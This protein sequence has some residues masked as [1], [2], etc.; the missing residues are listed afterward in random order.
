[1]AKDTVKRTKWW[2]MIGKV[3]TNPASLRGFLSKINKDLNKLDTNN[4]NILIKIW[5]IVLVG[6]PCQSSRA[7]DESHLEEFN[8][9]Q[10]AEVDT[11]K[12]YYVV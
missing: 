5:G 1:M 2:P 8:V 7:E 10:Q 3:T 11:V 9:L 12:F 6:L 4:P